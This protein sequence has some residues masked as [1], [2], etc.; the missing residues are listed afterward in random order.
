MSAYLWI[1]DLSYAN[2]LHNGG[3]LR[4]FN[5]S[6]ELLAKGHAVYFAVRLEDNQRAKSLEWLES[7]RADGAFTGCCELVPDAS[8]KRWNRTATLLLPFGLHQRAIRPF[9]A[10]ATDAISAAV[11]RYSPDVVIVSSLY[12]IFV[13]HEFTERPSIGDFS[14]SLSLYRWREFRLAFTQRRFRQALSALRDGY[15]FFFREMHS[16]R[17]YAAN[18]VVSP[19]D[20]RVFDRIGDARKNVCIANGVRIPDI[21]A[22]AKNPRQ[23]VFSGAMNFAPNFDGALW[24]LDRVFPLVLEKLPDTKMVIAGAKPDPKLLAR[25]RANVIVPGFVP[26]LNRVLAESALY[27]APLM[28]GSGFKNK[29]VEAAVNGT[30]VI[31]TT[32]A[33]EFLEPAIRDLIVV[34]D[35]PREMARAI[36]DF[37]DQPERYQDKLRRLRET[38]LRSFSWP[39]QAD[40]LIRLG[41][42]VSQTGAVC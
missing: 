22:V 31:G 39:A 27:V 23:I 28:S 40:E 2:R 32:F 20:K 36:C 3:L 6:R 33:V 42:R 24:F 13:A 10:S 12:Y 5:L 17:R 16:S 9:I 37:L 26:D 18:I 34:C 4:Y 41:D 8:V 25:A 29:I 7:L 21:T 11:S 14:D 15:H 35:D 38:V 1:I 19:V 30:Y